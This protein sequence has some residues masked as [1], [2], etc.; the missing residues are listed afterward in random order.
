MGGAA[1]TKTGPGR[2]RAQPIMQVN[3][4]SGYPTLLTK[5]VAIEVPGRK[6]SLVINMM[7]QQILNCWAL[8]WHCLH[9]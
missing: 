3:D 1:T 7:I 8:K 2:A 4:V 9:F 6:Q 5:I